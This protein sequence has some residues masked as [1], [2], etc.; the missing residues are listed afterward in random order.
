MPEA[1]R[2]DPPSRPVDGDINEQAVWV[3]LDPNRVYCE[4]NPNDEDTGVAEMTRLGWVVESARKDGPRLAGGTAASDGS[5]L[6]R[7]GQVLMSRDRS[8]H[9]EALQSAWAVA[10]QRSGAIGEPGNYDPGPT[11]RR[12]QFKDDPREYVSR[13]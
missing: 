9:Q 7:K 8:L 5:T 6:T 1:K 4:A 13:G 12:P 2:H 3:N 10:K 11:G